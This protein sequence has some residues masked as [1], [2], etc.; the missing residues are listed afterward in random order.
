MLAV[1][2]MHVPINFLA[3]Y[4]PYHRLIFFVPLLGTFRTGRWHGYGCINKFRI[5]SMKKLIFLAVC[6][7]A[8]G[9]PAF[10]QT[11]Q[12]LCDRAVTYTEQDS[13]PQAETY[14]RRALKL[15]PANPHNALL[16]SNLGT[17]QRRQRKYEKGFGVL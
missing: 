6:L 7:L 11:Y 15:E 9:M 5:I 16:F 2:C 4:C 13:L 17:I 14:I 1:S 3:W 8:S 12:E 10:A